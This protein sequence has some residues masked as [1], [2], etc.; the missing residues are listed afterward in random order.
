MTADEKSWWTL[1]KN[2]TMRG[3]VLVY[4]GVPAALVAYGGT[5]PRIVYRC[6]GNGPEDAVAR[7]LRDTQGDDATVG[8]CVFLG[9]GDGVP[10][11]VIAYTVPATTQERRSVRGAI[12][13]L[14]AEL[15]ATLTGVRRAA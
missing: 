1:A 15:W 11:Y 12:G 5:L 14:A 2:D 6:R 8:A 7:W 3:T 4:A 9:R 10:R 13:W